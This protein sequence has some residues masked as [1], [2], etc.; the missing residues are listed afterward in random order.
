MGVT[1]A[2]RKE[3][4]RVEGKDLTLAE[5]MSVGSQFQAEDGGRRS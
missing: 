3:H 2:D 4:Q 5:A 1:M